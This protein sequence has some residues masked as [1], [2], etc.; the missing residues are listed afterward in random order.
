M[1]HAASEKQIDGVRAYFAALPPAARRELDKIRAAVRNVAPDAVETI[2]YGIPAFKLNGR[3]LVYYAAWKSHTSL[4]PM[5]DAIRSAFA[6]E[7]KGYKTSK[8]TVQFPLAK[9]V[10][11]TLVKRLIK[12]RIAELESKKKSRS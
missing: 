8:G 2:S 6:D 3:I 7:L 4:Y 12:A 10:P 11:S 1:T 5:T 9:P